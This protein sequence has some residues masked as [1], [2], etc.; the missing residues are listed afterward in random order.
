M[1]N[2]AEAEDRSVETDD[3]I[4]DL[5][6]PA[7]ADAAFHAPFEVDENMRAGNAELLEL[8]HD[9]LVHHRGTADDD[10]GMGSQLRG[11]VEE[12]GDDPDVAF[13]DKAY[14]TVT[15]FEAYFVDSQSYVRTEDDM[16]VSV[17]LVNIGFTA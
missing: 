5:A 10:A 11:L 7:L 17:S 1:F 12:G 14:C 4:V 3:P 16:K 2:V 6:V 13:P 9:E 15:G 8:A